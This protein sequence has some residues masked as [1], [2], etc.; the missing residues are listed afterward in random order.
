MR[1]YIAEIC[2]ERLKGRYVNELNS[3]MWIEEIDEQNLTFKGKYSTGAGRPPPEELFA[4]NGHFQ[5]CNEKMCVISWIVNWKHEKKAYNSIA[6]F[7]GYG[8]FEEKDNV[9]IRTN[10]LLTY[11]DPLIP[12]EE[13]GLYELSQAKVGPNIFKKQL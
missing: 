1:A 12:S 10:W 7:N 3:T 2:W 9:T 11:L 8:V 5:K 4:V 13:I 6:S